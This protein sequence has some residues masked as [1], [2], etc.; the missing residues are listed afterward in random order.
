MIEKRQE[1][2]HGKVS[3]RIREFSSHAK[4]Q[5]APLG[6]SSSMIFGGVDS[7]SS[8]ANGQ[9]YHIGIA[10]LDFEKSPAR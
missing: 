10:E 8:I 7:R 6:N 3:H 9:L 4:I 1:M 2:R 5:K